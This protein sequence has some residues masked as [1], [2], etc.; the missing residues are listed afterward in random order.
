MRAHISQ[1]TNAKIFAN[2]FLVAHYPGLLGH[3]VRV[4]HF[5]NCLQN[6]LKRLEKNC[7]ENNPR[8]RKIKIPA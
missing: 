5:L 7:R 8:N 4:G 3:C 6:L 1:N 2:A